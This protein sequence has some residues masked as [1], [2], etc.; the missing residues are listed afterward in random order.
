V[1][2]TS[3]VFE[4]SF[5]RT[6]DVLRSE[7]LTAARASLNDPEILKELE[8]EIERDC[9]S[10]RSFLFAAQVGGLVGMLPYFVLMCGRV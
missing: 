8:D 1:S 10:L 6:V 7:H 5:N 2:G 9:D 4:A 3:S